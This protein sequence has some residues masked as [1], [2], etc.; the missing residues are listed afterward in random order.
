[1][2]KGTIIVDPYAFQYGYKCVAVQPVIVTHLSISDTYHFNSRFYLDI[3]GL[4][5]GIISTALPDETQGNK[6]GSFY[7]SVKYHDTKF[8]M[9]NSCYIFMLGE[10]GTVNMFVLF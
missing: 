9:S 8:E 6:Y 3:C 2:L 10:T 4:H 7:F 5:K 1:M